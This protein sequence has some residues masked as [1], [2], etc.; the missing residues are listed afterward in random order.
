[1][2]PRHHL[3]LGCLRRVSFQSKYPI[4][5]AHFSFN[6]TICP[7]QTTSQLELPSISILGKTRF[8]FTEF[9]L[10]FSAFHRT[11]CG[12]PYRWSRFL[13]VNTDIASTIGSFFASSFSTAA[14]LFSVSCFSFRVSKPSNATSRSVMSNILER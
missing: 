3:F 11:S 4:K 9:C 12:F 8:H 2:I 7:R 14:T 10:S 13:Y 1:M 6:L 5:Q